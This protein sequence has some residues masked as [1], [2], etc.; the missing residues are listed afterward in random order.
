M[1]HII[2]ISWPI[3]PVMTE[4]KNKKTVGFH[5]IKDFSQDKVRE[6]SIQL[7]SHSGTHVDAPSHFLKE[8]KTIDQM[9]LTNLVGNCIVLDM[10]VCA[11]Q[12]TRDCLFEHD[13]LIT[14]GGIV[15]LRTINSDISP[16][17]AF[18]P[19]FVY[20]SACGARYLA[21]KKIK[22]FGIDYLGIEHSQPGHPTHETL[23]N[24][25]ITIVEGL[26]LGHVKAGVYFFVCLPL[27]VVG[28]EAAPARAVLIVE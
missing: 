24:A 4:Y 26:R 23:M 16:T 9:L 10:T 17:D 2:D 27:S 8:G 15:L 28:L 3:S 22:A 20:L 14:E 25:D 19:Q 18:N 21:S 5:Q 11:E 7:G 13:S 12:I 6:S 1:R